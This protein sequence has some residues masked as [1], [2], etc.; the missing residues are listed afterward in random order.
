MR[1][2]VVGQ[3]QGG[4]EAAP[5]SRVLLTGIPDLVQQRTVISF[6]LTAGLRVVGRRLLSPRA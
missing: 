5:L 3:A 4:K 6:H 2:G 1:A